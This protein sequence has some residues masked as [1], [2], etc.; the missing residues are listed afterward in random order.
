MPRDL[1]TP[2]VLAVHAHPDDES[3][4]TGLAIAALHREGADVHVLTCT[5]GEQGEVIG[6]KYQGLIADRTDQLGGYRI[7]EL[8]SALGALGINPRPEFLGGATA[9]RDSGMVGT[10]SIEHPRA[11]A[12]SSDIHAGHTEEQVAQLQAVI[13]RLKP[14]IVFTYGPDGGYGHPDHIKTHRVTH[15]AVVGLASDAWVPNEIWWAVTPQRA[16]QRALTG[17]QVPEGWRLP[18]DGEIALVDEADIDVLLTGNAD[19]VAAKTN[20]MA[21]HATQLWVANGEGTDVNPEAREGRGASEE[22][23]YAL[24]NL[25]AQ[26]ILPVEGFQLGWR[27]ETLPADSTRQI[28]L[29]DFNCVT[30]DAS[31]GQQATDAN[32]ERADE[33]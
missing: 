1:E 21:A 16:Y 2:R 19:D 27:N 22:T 20:A 5:L 6:D 29:L 17:V 28:S 31:T 33:V 32:R 25:I 30:N 9:W 13:Q 23:L 3:I 18:D 10:P 12:G 14:H 26:P 7:A 4:V 15:E 24:S 8:R 11:F